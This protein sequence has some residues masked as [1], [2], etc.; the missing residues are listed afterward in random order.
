MR[1]W[2]LWAPL[3]LFAIFVG[4]AMMGLRREPATLTP[5]R[6]VGQ[7]MPAFS[8]PPMLPSRPGTSG[9]GQG[10][11]LVNLFG[12]WC[13]PCIA[14]APQLLQLRE[15]G[16]TI[17]AVAIRDRPEDVRRF[18]AEHGDP[19]RYIGSD[20]ISHVQVTLGSSGVPETFL[21]DGAGLIRAHHVGPILPEH[22]PDLVS[23]A[24]ALQ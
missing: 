23:Q 15:A 19:F 7:P 24:R 4:V 17:D 12:S 16:L 5:S 3:A 1:R 8:L 20:P 14:E 22:V 11:R 18:L 6:L 10:P 2:L 21:V 9:G 13:V